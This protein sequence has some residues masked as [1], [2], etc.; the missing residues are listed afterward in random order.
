MSLQSASAYDFVVNGIYYNILSTSDQTCSVTFKDTKF[1]SYKGSIVIPSSV[2]YNSTRY[3][4]KKIESSAFS[5]CEGLASVT[6][7]SGITQISAQAFYRCIALTSV[8]IPSSVTYISNDAFEGSGLSRITVNSQ[9]S[10]YDSRNSCN[11]IISTSNNE[12]IVGCKT[13]VIPSNVK[14]IGYN[15]FSMCEGLTSINIPNSVTNIGMNAFAQCTNLQSINIPTS[16]KILE[17]GVFAYCEKLEAIDIPNSVESIKINAF[18]GA[19]LKTIRIPSSV[20]SIADGAFSSQ[21]LL[22]ISVDATNAYYDSRESCNAIIET[23]TNKLMVGSINTVIP[24]T[25]TS[26]G[27]NA[28]SGNKDITNIH[29][30]SSVTTLG[31]HSF[32]NC[33]NLVDVYNEATEPQTIYWFTF[34]GSLSDNI[35]YKTLHVRKECVDKY[36]SANYWS[37]FTIIGEV[38]PLYSGV[39]GANLNYEIYEDYSMRIHGTGS[40]NTYTSTSTPWYSQRSNIT[41]IEVEEGATSLSPYAFYYCSNAKTIKL[42]STLKTLGTYC[43]AYSGVESMT[44]PGSITSYGTYALAYCSKMKELTLEEGITNI[45]NSG[46]RS[47]TLLTTINLP[48]TLTSINKNS[49]RGC[50]SLKTIVY[51]ATRVPS[52]GE[53]ILRDDFTSI[54]TGTLYVRKAGLA[55]FK[56]SYPWSSFG[57]IVAL[58]CT[59][60]KDGESYSETENKEQEEITYTRTFN[61]TNWQAL[62]VPFAMSYDDWKEDFEIAE[63]ADVQQYDDNYDGKADRTKI[64]ARKLEAGESTTANTPYFIK[65]KTTGAKMITVADATL[66]ATAENIVNKKSMNA[67]FD[68]TGTYNKVTNMATKGY[69]AMAGGKICQAESDAATL[70]PFRWYLSVKDSNGNSMSLAK[71]VSLVFDDE[72]TEVNVVESNVNAEDNRI[73]T[74]DGR[75]VGTDIKALGKGLYIK[76]KKTFTVK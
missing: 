36:K 13:T 72:V 2:T 46:V 75:F 60:L 4:V 35:S 68:F 11:A 69:Y 71:V 47:C 57:N 15:A 62:Y 14:S 61:N 39:C 58:Y 7:P 37:Q 40:M 74:I 23:S 44:L 70:N 59:N 63:I 24:K 21:N 3:T 38:F 25:I 28:F 9:N 49:F 12:L 50:T 65:A 31:T 33:P 41:S 53:D 27:D 22:S 17:S 18:N 19:G 56:S 8:N 26:I 55:S 29:I 42:P 30:P 1:N 54:G 43:M 67:D 45:G 66:C 76:N 32:Y 5:M 20:K 73:F 6:I 10:Y 51:P 52:M 34:H 16:L 64:E 48:S